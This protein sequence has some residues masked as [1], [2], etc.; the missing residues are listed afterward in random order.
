LPGENLTRV[1]AQE[2]KSLVSVDHYDVTLDLTT[3]PEIFRS[4]TV[5]TFDATPG[6]STFID[7]LTRTVHSVTLNAAELDVAA[8]NDGI[9]IQL[10]GLAAHNVLTVVADAE[11]TNT[12]E[13]L[14]RFV[15]P[16]D[17]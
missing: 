13:G 17:N 16:V 12:G 8:V 14:H 5:V 4:T 6:S 1:E 3:G 11:Y 9:R 7:A 10:D 15:D 2:R